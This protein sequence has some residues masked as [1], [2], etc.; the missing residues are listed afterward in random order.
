[1]MI[2]ISNLNVY[3]INGMRH[4]T[5]I[6]KQ[7]SQEFKTTNWLF[8]FWQNQTRRSLRDRRVL[9]LSTIKNK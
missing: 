2:V 6:T 9:I 5:L 3:E 1:M 8:L 7:Y 4:Q